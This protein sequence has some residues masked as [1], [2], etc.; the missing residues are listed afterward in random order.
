MIN[1]FFFGVRCRAELCE[2]LQTAR[3]AG[4]FSK[5]FFSRVFFAKEKPLNSFARK[6]ILFNPFLVSDSGKNNRA[7]RGLDVLWY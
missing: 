7:S 6:N 5:S 1:G 4:F 3:F 2:A